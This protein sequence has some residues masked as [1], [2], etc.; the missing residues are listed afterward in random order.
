M[1]FTLDRK[2]LDTLL[3]VIMD[4]IGE[5]ESIFGK[6]ADTGKQTGLTEKKPYVLKLVDDAVIGLNAAGV[7]VNPTAVTAVAGP[8]IDAVIAVAQVATN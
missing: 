7:N 1:A 5:A 8:L 3:L 4:G 6:S 2:T